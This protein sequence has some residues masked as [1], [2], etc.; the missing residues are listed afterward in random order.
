MYLPRGGDSQAWDKEEEFQ[1]GFSPPCYEEGTLVAAQKLSIYYRNR[2]LLSYPIYTALGDPCS[3]SI[4]A[5]EKV[6]KMDSSSTCN[7]ALKC[8]QDCINC[9]DKCPKPHD[10]ILPTRVIDCSDPN[11]PN[12]LTTHGVHGAYLALSYVWGEKQPHKTT[13]ININQY[14]QEIKLDYLPRTIRDAIWVTKSCGQRYLWVDSLCIIQD[15]RQDKIAEI[16]R[17]PQIFRDAYFT[18]IASKSSKVSDG[19]LQDCPDT[20]AS[21]P[22]LPTRILCE[23]GSTVGIMSIDWSPSWKED[24]D[25]IKLPVNTRAWCLEE[26]LLSVRALVYASDTLYFQCQTIIVGIGDAARQVKKAERAFPREA[27]SSIYILP[28]TN[29][30][31]DQRGKVDHWREIVRDYTRRVVTKPEDKLTALAGVAY[32][33]SQLWNSHKGVSSGISQGYVAGWWRDTL[34]FDLL[35]HRNLDTHVFTPRQ[36]DLIPHLL[37][38]PGGGAPSWSWAS[39]NGCV[40]VAESHSIRIFELCDCQVVLE[41]PLLPFGRVVEAKSILEGRLIEANW[42][43]GATKLQLESWTRFARGRPIPVSFD[44]WPDS[45]D[46]IS[47]HVWIIPMYYDGPEQTSPL[48]TMNGLILQSSSEQ[49][50]HRVGYFRGPIEIRNQDDRETEAERII[51]MRSKRISIV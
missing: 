7:L 50:Y 15:S 19:F 16:A 9:H 23:D 39:V 42:E 5:R 49:E 43:T 8:I 26:R 46:T 36:K 45:S 12:L 22:H 32:Q 3:T 18:I 31:S 38:R 37:P 2:S 35:W 48:A 27:H 28:D 14:T 11:K 25:S 30:T 47:E 4:V 17:I 6:L 21:D 41:S 51:K 40:S 44:A 29:S 13:E 20:A 33:F 24:Y 34:E 10:S 1:V